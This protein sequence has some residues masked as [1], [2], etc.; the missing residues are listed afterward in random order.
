[1]AWAVK[2][3]AACALILFAFAVFAPSVGSGGAPM[4][5]TASAVS[6]DEARLARLSS[7]TKD[8]H[9]TI[10]GRGKTAK[11]RNEQIALATGAVES[12]PGFALPRTASGMSDTA[13]QCLTQ[14]IY[15]ESAT[16]P[17]AGKRAVAQVVLNR[18][19]HPA[20]PATVCGVVYEGWSA[21]VCQFS[22]VC[23]GSL[24]RKPSAS[25]WRESRDV[26]RA[27]LSGHVETDVGTATHYHADY[28][29]PRWAYEL[30]KVRRVGQHLFYRFPGRSGR[31]ASF[32]SRWSGIERIPA[33]DFSRAGALGDQ[34]ADMGPTG[35][36]VP[37]RDPTDRRADNDVGGRMDPSKSW[38][39][40]I[41]DPV[42]ASS[43]FRAALDS[44]PRSDASGE[45]RP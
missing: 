10:L 31:A 3:L 7:I 2:R 11:E 38:R 41:P 15:Y 35:S 21:P 14:A 22:F 34:A 30:D 39:L 12:L 4:L 18:V 19:R 28:V 5:A 8:D 23:D 6:P 25:L 24:R 43:G 26:A 33:I 44:Q 45:V 27:A 20:Y 32:T 42:T 37:L 9:A 17:L 13:Q 36:L 1:M 29:L 16:E 40:A